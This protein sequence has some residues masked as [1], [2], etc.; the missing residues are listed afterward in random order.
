M[1]W[2]QALQRLREANAPAVL[3]T[4][5]EARGHTPRD[6]GAK[7]VVSAAGTWGTVGGGNLE[8][9]A[10]ARARAMLA[11]NST[12]PETL[13][14]GLNEHAV[15]EHG[16]QCCGGVARILLEP[17]PARA[18]VAI[19]GAGHVG[20]ELLH[21]LSRLPLEIHVTDS[22]QQLLEGLAGLGTAGPARVHLHHSLVPD[23]VVG[24]LP[25]GTHVLIMTH[26][27]SEDFMLCD[28]ALRHTEL[29]AIGLIGSKAKWSRFEKKLRGEGHADDQIQRI[30]CP[31]GLQGIPGKDPAVIAI[32]VAARLLQDLEG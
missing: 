29:G 20:R 7:M 25:P 27:H 24:G 26:D 31:I 21:I 8:A 23:S 22:R 28:A 9:T 1:D 6:A 11:Q 30:R 5:I 16:R 3:A 14:F 17:V 2:L 15:V 10:V 12:G 32:G 19:F 4:V 13:A 18:N